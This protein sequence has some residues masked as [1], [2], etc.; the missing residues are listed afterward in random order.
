MLGWEVLEGFR[1][2]LQKA[3]QP[4]EGAA[5]GWE[6]LGPGRPFLGVLNFLSRPFLSGSEAFRSRAQGL[7]F[8]GLGFRV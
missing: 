5:L 7:G 6:A 1:E 4:C 2:V 3:W 8:K